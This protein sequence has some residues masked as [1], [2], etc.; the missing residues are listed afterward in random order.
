MNTWYRYINGKY[1]DISQ[2]RKGRQG[3][4]PGCQ[5]GRWSL[6]STPPVTIR[7]IILTTFCVCYGSMKCCSKVIDKGVHL[8][9]IIIL[10]KWDVV[11][12]SNEDLVPFC[13]N[14]WTNGRTNERMNEQI[15]CFSSMIYST[16]GRLRFLNVLPFRVLL[17]EI[18]FH[19]WMRGLKLNRNCFWWRPMGTMAMNAYML[20]FYENE[21]HKVTN[22]SPTIRHL[23]NIVN[24]MGVS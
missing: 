22:R 15:I 20:S 11:F 17:L 24:L 21:P 2:K 1:M 6:P 14:L 13:L 5:W 19:R 16:I 10:I 9:P 3:D 23:S 18:L 12:T 7:A 4:S 8:T